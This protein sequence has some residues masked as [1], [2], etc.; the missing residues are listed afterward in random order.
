[1][2][3]FRLVAPLFGALALLTSALFPGEGYALDY[4]KNIKDVRV[5]GIERADQNTVRYYIHSRKGNVYDSDTVAEDI[6][7]LY[8]LGFFDA[9]RLDLIEEDDGLVLTYLFTEKPFVH[10]INLDGVT[11]IKDKEIV[12]RVKTQ[13]GTFFRQDLIPWDESRIRQVYRNKGFYF[14]DVKTVVKRLPDNLV[15]VEFHVDE[16]KKI[17]VA[18]I[19]FRDVNRFSPQ[20]LRWQIETSA[21]TWASFFSDSGAYKKNALKTDLLKL[22][23]FYHD[24]GY[25]KARIDDPE[26]EIDKE[27]RSIYITFPVTEGEQYRVGEI[28]VEGDD[29]YTEEELREKLTL[30]KG[31]VFN[32]TLFR[33]EIFAITD[34]YAQKGYAYANVIPQLDIDEDQRLVNIAVRTEK[35]RKIYIGS[36]N[37]T[38]NEETRDRVI[39]RQFRLNE[40]ELFDSEKLRRSRE[41]INRLGYFNSVDIEQRSGAEEDTV[42]IET[43][44][45]EM[46][47]GEISFAVGYSSVEN[48]LVQGSIKWKNLDGRGQEFRRLRRS[49]LPTGRLLPLLHRTGH[50]GSRDPR[51]T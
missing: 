24:N 48:V 31:E 3:P 1:M 33:Q 11:E 38:G 28:K 23:A 32:K 22:E 13:K 7:R 2:N 6:R 25:I 15:D 49:L 46:N 12:L 27:W 30:S 36:I 29:I 19:D 18:R 10:K 8:K 14:T 17:N 50:H 5:V 26:V 42:D 45:E 51:R 9:I 41:R 43:K 4:F 40:G 20:T 37:I 39:R 34:L 47:T 35:G 21:V 16:G 44:V